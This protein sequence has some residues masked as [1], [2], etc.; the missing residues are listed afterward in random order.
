MVRYAVICASNQNRS[1]EA[2]NVLSKRGFNVRSF[3]TGTQVRLPGPSIDKPN[4]Y[5]FGTPYDQVYQELK[6]KDPHLYTQNGL[7]QM[8]DRNRKIK[9]APER[10]QEADEL[11]DVI[12]TCEER[13]YD[14]VCENLLNRGQ[15]LNT[16]VHVINIDIKDNHEDAAVG[17]RMILQLA[18]MIELATDLDE[19]LEQIII[20]FQERHGQNVLYSVSF[21]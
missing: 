13:C 10:F 4:V 7:L 18:N 2:H 1:M 14:A 5:P 9:A 8:L 15:K 12:I 17:G 19:E 20:S 11:F 6:Q 16:P 3:G 21:Y